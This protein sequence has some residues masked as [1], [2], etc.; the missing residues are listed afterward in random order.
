[1]KVRYDQGQTWRANPEITEIA[2]AMSFSTGDAPYFLKHAAVAE[3]GLSP[4]DL[5]RKRLFPNGEIAYQQRSDDAPPTTRPLLSTLISALSSSD[6]PGDL[7]RAS[8]II[9]IVSAGLTALMITLAF[10]A[11]GYWLEGAVA[12]I[13]GGLSSAYLVRSSFGRIDRSA[14][15]WIDVSDVR[16]GHAISAVKNSC[17]SGW[18]VATGMTANIFMAWYGNRIDLD[19][20]CA[21][22]WLLIRCVRI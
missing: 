16:P 10:G 17:G 13:G 19:G 5:H 15:P 7:L 12:A 9:L 21:Y 18:G 11:A 2:G 20:N 8:H 1:M 6:D 22:V 3:K 14:E 4:D